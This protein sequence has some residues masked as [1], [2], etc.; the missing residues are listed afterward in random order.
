LF[1]AAKDRRPMDFE[2]FRNCLVSPAL[3]AIAD[4]WDD[5]R[6]SAPMPSW[7][8]LR[9]SRIAPHLSILWAYKYDAAKDAF[10]GRLAGSAISWGVDKSFRDLALGEIWTSDLTPQIHQKMLRAISEPAICLKRGNLFRHAERLIEGERI[11]LPLA[12]DG[13][14]GDGLLG[15]SAYQHPFRSLEMGNVELLDGDEEWYSVTFGAARV[16]TA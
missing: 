6:G 16:G 5:A 11:A 9:P 2:D 13:V 3:R 8:Q 12:G 14:R 10:T 7:E 15:A 1:Y 4:H